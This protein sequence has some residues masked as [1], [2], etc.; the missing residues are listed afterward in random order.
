M[1]G[2]GLSHI[3]PLLLIHSVAVIRVLTGLIE[4]HLYEK[5]SNTLPENTKS[6]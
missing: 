4:R 3:T 1:L 5:V 6:H 2:N